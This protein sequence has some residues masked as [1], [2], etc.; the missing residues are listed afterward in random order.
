VVFES[1][2][3]VESLRAFSPT[4]YVGWNMSVPDQFRAD[5]I[6]NELAE[7]EKKREF[8]EL[9]I[10]CL[11]Q[12]H[13]SGTSPDCPTPE[14]CMADNDLAFG[15]IVE[16]LSR[17]RFWPQMAIFAIEDDPQAGWDHVSGYRTIA[18]CI[19]PYV[20]RGAVVSTQYNTTSMLR[21][22][23]QILGMPPMNQF[24]ASASPMFECFHDKADL[25]PF[26]AAPALVVLDQ[27]NPKTTA[28]SDPILRRDAMVSASL[29]FRE[30]D[31]APEDVL[32]RI[33]WRAMRGSRAPY[34]EWA[35][36][37]YEDEDEDE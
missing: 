10:I 25:T 33:L 37:A 29:N 28:I 2:P 12:D 23:E 32:N 31:R 21:T 17:S 5:F 16:A 3:S 8:P 13:T 18:F 24:D 14:A 26:A 11:P 27:M 6:L 1:W 22:I 15:R 36:T 7:Y 35:T 19:S 34:P 4:S 20:N 30:V 9:V